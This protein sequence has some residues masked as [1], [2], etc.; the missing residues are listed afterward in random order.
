MRTPADRWCT[1]CQT[2]KPAAD[3]T[4]NARGYKST[5][6]DACLAAFTH[7][8]CPRC[9]NKKPLADFRVTKMNGK[10][11]YVSRCLYCRTLDN[12]KPLPPVTDTG[13]SKI[14]FGCKR[15]L[16][17]SMFY[18]NTD[19]GW[20]ARCR[21]CRLPVNKYVPPSKRVRPPKPPAPKKVVPDLEKEV[22]KELRRCT[23][24]NRT[25]I[26][27][28][29]RL[30][31]AKGYATQDV[32]YQALDSRMAFQ[33]FCEWCAK[34][35]LADREVGGYYPLTQYTQDPAVRATYEQETGKSWGRRQ[36]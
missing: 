8:V 11:Y 26:D 18:A 21:D 36:N 20:A 9:E 33:K 24:D 34:V 12:N 4:P 13:R 6:C 22:N 14:C 3:F 5:K 32:T 28:L 27:R 30:T 35:A 1:G 31:M 7:K 10:S 16:D 23:R 15:T 17:E 2:T 29:I 25:Q 19:S